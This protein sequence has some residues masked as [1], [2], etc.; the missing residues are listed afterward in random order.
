MLPYV[1]WLGAAQRLPVGQQRRLKHHCGSGDALIVYNNSDSWSCWCW[2]CHDGGHKNKAH[3]FLQRKVDTRLRTDAPQ[4]LVPIAEAPERAQNLCYNMMLCKGIDPV[5]LTSC[6][7]FYSASERRLV[8]RTPNGQLLG[9]ALHVDQLP[10]WRAYYQ[11]GEYPKRVYL[12]GSSTTEVVLTEDLFSAIKVN[13]ASDKSAIALLGTHF[14][15]SVIP[16]GI[17]LVHIMLD[18]DAAG[19]AGAQSIAQVLNFYG[20]RYIIHRVPDGK[21]PKD[22]TISQL[23]SCFKCLT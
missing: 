11:R 14:D 18:G 2:R 8:I 22:L 7:A 5:M 4:D 10:K 9:R 23:R 19:Y 13:Y 12:Q 15:I 20:V 17:D 3:V 21:D 16:E 1:E 6:T